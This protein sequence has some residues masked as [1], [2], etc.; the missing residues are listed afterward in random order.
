MQS[1]ELKEPAR[2][3]NTLR[4]NNV[5]TNIV[6]SH[7][8]QVWLRQTLTQHIPSESLKTKYTQTTRLAVHMIAPSAFCQPDLH[9]LTSQ[10]NQCH[11]S[12][13]LRLTTAFTTTAYRKN[14]GT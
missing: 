12:L 1:V 11:F 6:I 14:T 9:K 7:S 4:A 13:R 10:R 3:R 2:T 5:T 8:Y